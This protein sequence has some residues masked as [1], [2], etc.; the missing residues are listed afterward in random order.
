MVAKLVAR[1]G[2]L[3][4]RLRV[5]FGVEPLYKESDPKPKLVEHAQD[6]GERSLYGEVVTKGLAFGPQP[7]L[8]VGSLAQVV[9][10]D[11]HRCPLGVGP[12]GIGRHVGRVTHVSLLKRVIESSLRGHSVRLT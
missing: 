5:E 9:E 6:P 8:E 4:Q 1:V 11:T 3:Q 10:G 2:D 7:T 12:P